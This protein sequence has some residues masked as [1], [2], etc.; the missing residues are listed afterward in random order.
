MPRTTSLRVLA[1]APGTRHLGVAVFE[2]KELVRFGVKTFEGKKTAQSLSTKIEKCLED[3]HQRHLPTTLAVEEVFY[4]QARRSPLLRPLITTVKRWGRKKGLRVVSYLPPNVKER[5]C[6]G[7][8]TRRNL[9]EAVVR[10]FSFLRS[11]LKESRT[12]NARQ[13]WQQMFDAVALGM[14]VAS[15]APTN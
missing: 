4:A 3:L 2:G 8:R 12:H 7:K 15:D 1:I 5:I 13:Y 9:A 14:L 10:R 6:T 11:F